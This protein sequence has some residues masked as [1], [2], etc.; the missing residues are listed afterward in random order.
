MAAA[1]NQIGSPLGGTRAF[2]AAKFICAFIM[3]RQLV[4]DC[5]L[6]EFISFGLFFRLA[7]SPGSAR[8]MPPGRCTGRR[9]AVHGL[10][11]V[12]NAASI[13][14]R[15]APRMERASSGAKIDIPSRRRASHRRQWFHA[16]RARRDAA[17]CDGRMHK[18][19]SATSWVWLHCSRRRAARPAAGREIARRREGG[20]ESDEAALV[21]RRAVAAPLVGRQLPAQRRRWRRARRDRAAAAAAGSRGSALRSSTSAREAGLCAGRRS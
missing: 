20:R 10:V 6:L 15:W 3:D 19:R 12:R 17:C 14:W 5:K 21:W 7:P 16:R 1:A 11:K 8:G 18:G 13:A 9:A 2:P 4:E